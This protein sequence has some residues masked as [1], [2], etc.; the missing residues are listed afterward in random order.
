VTAERTETGWRINGSKMYYLNR[1]NAD[2]IILIARV[3]ADHS[4][5][6]REFMVDCRLP[7]VRVTRSTVAEPGL[8]STQT[9]AVHFQDVGVPV[10][11]C[12]GFSADGEERGI[13]KGLPGRLRHAQFEPPIH[14]H[15][16][17]GHR[18]GID[19]HRRGLA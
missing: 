16:G 10:D 1:A 2:F 4:N 12:L 3:K 8:R 19:R 11:A 7:G 13:A 5:C 15:A 9:S 17:G 18:S 6:T 14:V